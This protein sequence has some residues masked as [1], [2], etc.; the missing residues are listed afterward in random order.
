MDKTYV[1]NWSPTYS[2][3]VALID[4]QHKELLKLT[5]D[6][7]NHC[8]GDPESEHAYFKKVIKDAINYVKVHFSTEEQIMIKT[9]YPGY[10]EH[11]R[12]HDSF[13]LKVLG[14]VKDYEENNSVHLVDFTHFLKD[15]VLTHIAISDKAYFE[16]FKK[17]AVRKSDGTLSISKQDVPT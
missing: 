12:Q 14:H 1:V 8:V 11:K 15:W 6:L 13:V 9:G 16:Y 5:N 7:Y 10:T 4:N 17:I 2:V 3:G